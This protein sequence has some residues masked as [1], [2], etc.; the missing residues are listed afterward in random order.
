M[1][2]R[3]LTGRSTLGDWLAHPVGG[4]LVLDLL[5]RQGREVSQLGPAA[6]VMS[7]RRLVELSQGLV[8]PS[9]VDDLVRAANDG[10]LVTEEPEE[11]E[12]PRTR[13]CA[14]STLPSGRG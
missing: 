4:P 14:A 10:R 7:L 13:S 1:T 6:R 8:P 9:V 12:D 2:E 11:P 5:A 3:Q